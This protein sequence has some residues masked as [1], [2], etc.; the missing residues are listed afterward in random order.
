MKVR[1]DEETFMKNTFAK[2][3]RIDFIDREE[4]IDEDIINEL[5]SLDEIL[6]ELGYEELFAKFHEI[7]VAEVD[8][9]EDEDE[10][11]KKNPR[12]EVAKKPTKKVVEEEEDDDEEEPVKKPSKKAPAKKK[13]PELDWEEISD[14]GIGELVDVIDSYNLDLDADEFD[15][16][17]DLQEA[18]AEALDIEV[19]KKKPAAKKPTKKVVEE[20]D[21]EEEKV[22]ARKSS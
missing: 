4:P 17:A 6:Q 7:D 12:K 8:L 5:P 3:S 21:E 1:W 11:P 13:L 19:Q 22:P 2:A 14:M 15:D 18:I 9:D 10:T 20:D 16:A